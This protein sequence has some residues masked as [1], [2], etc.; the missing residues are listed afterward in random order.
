MNKA[1]FLNLSKNIYLRLGVVIF[2]LALIGYCHLSGK[3]VF[4]IAS[5]S[6]EPTITI[7]SLIFT[8]PEYKYYP[9]QVIS[10]HK[11]MEEMLPNSQDSAK[12]NDYGFNQEFVVSHRIM[13]VQSKDNVEWFRTKGDAN[14]KPDYYSVIS[15][16]V[17]GRV[18]LVVPYIGY[19]FLI[20]GFSKYI[21]FLILISLLGLTLL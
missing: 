12:D 21:S 7:G 6:M 10:F 18:F 1:F 2:L 5:G 8:T 20:S 13:S 11:T 19:I 17:I 14:D 9:G 4:V 16:K 3:R 15:S